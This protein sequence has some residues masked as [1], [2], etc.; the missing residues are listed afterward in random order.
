MLRFICY[1]GDGIVSKVWYV[2]VGR[3]MGNPHRLVFVRLFDV[4]HADDE[5]AAPNLPCMLRLLEPGK[6]NWSGH[7]LV[8][9]ALEAC[10]ADGNTDDANLRVTMAECAAVASGAAKIAA[11]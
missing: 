4:D 6:H 10:G 8:K 5:A 1:S 3:R 11:E 2:I 9:L 7:V